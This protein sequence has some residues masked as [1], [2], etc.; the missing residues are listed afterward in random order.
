MPQPLPDNPR[1]AQV[2]APQ[3]LAHYLPMFAPVEQA[4]FEAG[5]QVGQFCGRHT[6]DHVESAVEA[7]FVTARFGAFKGEPARYVFGGEAHPEALFE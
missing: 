7:E 3:C 2:P 6:T 4:R 5:Q 1:E